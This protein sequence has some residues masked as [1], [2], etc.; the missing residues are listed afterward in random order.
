MKVCRTTILH[1][2]A[3][4]S[5]WVQDNSDNSSLSVK[6]E[7]VP[8]LSNRMY[9]YKSL[10][11]A[12]NIDGK[13]SRSSSY[14]GCFSMNYHHEKKTLNSHLKESRNYLPLCP[15]HNAI[16]IV[17]CSCKTV[18]LLL[19]YVLLLLLI[20]GRKSHLRKKENNC[21]NRWLFTIMLPT[22][23]CRW[24]YIIFSTMPLVSPSRSESYIHAHNT[25]IIKSKSVIDC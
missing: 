21:H 4:D 11:H 25:V 2:I 6:R 7:V 17:Q 18:D 5:Q 19:E 20:R 16:T 14:P 1:I 22:S 23:F 13:I 15:S 10:G 12:N 9:S 3:L 8:T 24:S